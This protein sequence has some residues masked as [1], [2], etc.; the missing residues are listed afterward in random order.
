LFF[1]SEVISAISRLHENHIVY[2]DLKPENIMLDSHGHTVLVDF[3]LT[4][5]LT[6]E[7]NFMAN[8][9]VGTAE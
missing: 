6:K 9:F 1:T 8:E 5:V 2:R 3:G 4:K 7:E